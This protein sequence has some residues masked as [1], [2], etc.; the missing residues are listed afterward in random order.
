MSTG[1]IPDRRWS[2][3]RWGR[4]CWTWPCHQS[5]GAHPY[6]VPP[7]HTA[8]ARE[9]L[10]PN[11][12]LAPEVHVVRDTDPTSARALGRRVLAD[13][14]RLPNYRAS[15]TRLGFTE[16]DLDHGGS[17][18]LIDVVVAWGTDD[19]IARRVDDHL[20]AGADHVCLQVLTPTLDELPLADWQALAPILLRPPP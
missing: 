2:S 10:G 5:L 12:I 8:I 20:A 19:E 14:L 16:D 15:F 1:S 18:R 6:L 4:G 9:V 7:E 3:R 13:N 11:R 17:N